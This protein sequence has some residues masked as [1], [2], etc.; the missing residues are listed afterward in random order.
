MPTWLTP[1]ALK[2][3][4]KGLHDSEIRCGIKNE[5]PAGGIT[6]WIDYGSRTEKATFYG[7]IVGDQQVWPAADRLAAGFKRPR[8]AFSLL[9][10]MPKR[11]PVDRRAR[12]QRRKVK[13]TASVPR[14]LHPPKW[15]KPQLTRLVDEAPAGDGWLHE[16]KYDGYRMHARIDGRKIKLLTRTGLDWSHRYRRT[17]EALALAE[18]EVSL[19]RRRAVR[20]E[21]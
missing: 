20:A 21:R 3:V 6:A 14:W 8:C 18:G 10:P 2:A 11:T 5:P 19:S 4:L 9:A 15:I 13:S 1:P 16:I 7:T 17:I 12:V